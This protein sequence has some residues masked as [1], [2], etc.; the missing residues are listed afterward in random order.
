VTRAVLDPNVIVA[1]A[2]S[3]AG[4]PA[5]CLRAHAEGRFE[6]VVSPKLIAELRFVFRRRKLRPYL[7]V[8][9]GERLVAALARD[10][11]VAGDPRDPEPLPRDPADDYL[12]AVARATAAHVLVTGDR[13]LL[14]IE[15]PELTIATPRAFLDLLPA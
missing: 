8:E 7:T 4:V 2:I 3:P 6:L 12:I 9:Q 11:T 14:E 15:L 10:A 1:A 5:D 13:D